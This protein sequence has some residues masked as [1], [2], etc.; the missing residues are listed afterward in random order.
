MTEEEFIIALVG[1]VFGT[2]IAGI[3]IGSFFQVIKTWI[4]R[5]KSDTELDPR[6]FKALSEFK[7]N[8]EKRLSNLEAIVLSDDQFELDEVPLNIK[9]E[10]ASSIEIE[11]EEVR[12]SKSK[13]SEKESGNLRNNGFKI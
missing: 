3:F 4:N 5:N 9:K 13:S 11:E 8:T 7:R 10:E 12:G 2:V 6:F 1:I